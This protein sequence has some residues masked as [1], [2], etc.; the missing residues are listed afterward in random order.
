M[1][2]GSAVAGLA[3]MPARPTFVRNH[4]GH[5]RSC[6]GRFFGNDLCSD[7][8]L[9]IRAS[10][11]ADHRDNGQLRSAVGL[12]LAPPAT[13]HAHGGATKSLVDAD[14]KALAAV[15]ARAASFHSVNPRSGRARPLTGSPTCREPTRPGTPEINSVASRYADPKG[16]FLLG[17]ECDENR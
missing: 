7:T 3:S 15:R 5:E 12:S 2:P 1:R 17:R 16:L 14:R 8:R 4:V 6:S 11:R 10:C 9:A 13:P